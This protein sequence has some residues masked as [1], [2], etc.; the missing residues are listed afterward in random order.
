MT[1]NGQNGNGAPVYAT[2]KG[3]QNGSLRTGPKN[4]LQRIA[5]TKP[6]LGLPEAERIFD[7]LA[8]SGVSGEAAIPAAIT[9]T[10]RLFGADVVVEAEA[11]AKVSEMEA[12]AYAAEDARAD[13]EAAMAAEIERIEEGIKASNSMAASV[14]SIAAGIRNKAAAVANYFNY[15]APVAN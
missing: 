2:P 13:Y 8:G 1:N 10:A 4:V 14:K 9:A 12:A 15:K 11:A 3:I 7:D 6:V 5:G